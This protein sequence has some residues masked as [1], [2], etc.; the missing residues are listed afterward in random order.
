MSSNI[1]VV[2]HKVKIPTRTPILNEN[3]NECKVHN[4]VLPWY[5]WYIKSLIVDAENKPSIN[6]IYS[7]KRTQKKKQKIRLTYFEGNQKH[8]T[9]VFIFM[10]KCK[11]LYHFL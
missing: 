7:F 8:F 4:S 3:K 1:R 9:H 10:W 2:Q 5:A 11:A 6:F